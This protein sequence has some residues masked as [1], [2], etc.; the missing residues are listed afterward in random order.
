MVRWRKM[1]Q[2]N[3]HPKLAD[4]CAVH[5]VG[6]TTSAPLLQAYR[7]S[8][9]AQGIVH[10]DPP[11]RGSCLVVATH[12]ATIIYAPFIVLGKWL[13]FVMACDCVGICLSA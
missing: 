6:A 3:V 7:E 4:R 1:F 8:L 13:P 5:I 2:S 11:M 10:V 12:V 9:R